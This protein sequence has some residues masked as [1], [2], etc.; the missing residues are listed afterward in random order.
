MGIPR[1]HPKARFV[2]HVSVMLAFLQGVEKQRRLKANR[3]LLHRLKGEHQH[4]RC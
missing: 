4:L 2:T 3:D 1:A